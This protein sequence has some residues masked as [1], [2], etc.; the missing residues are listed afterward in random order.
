M[1][2]K[3][4]RI[5]VC[6]YD[7]VAELPEAD[8]K[9]LLAAREATKNAY[10]PYS[11]FCVGAALLLENGEVIAGSNQENADFTDGLCAERV[12]LFYANSTYPDQAVKA[13]AVTAKNANGIVENPAQP[14]G[15]CRQVLVETESR[16]NNSIRLILDGRKHIQVLEGADNLLPFAFKPKDLE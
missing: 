2:R 15:S 3:E 13:I 12:A 9:L 6:E 11:K 16:Y 4:L 5:M 14:C 8:Q 1:R 10:A 7:A